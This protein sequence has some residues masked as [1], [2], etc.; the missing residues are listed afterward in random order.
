MTERSIKV[1]I[2]LRQAH[3]Y[4]LA[5]LDQHGGDPDWSEIAQSCLSLITH[6][7]CDLTAKFTDVSGYDRVVE[8]L[9][10]LG[11]DQDEA[12]RITRGLE[13]AVISYIVTHIPEFGSDHYYEQVSVR[14]VNDTTA[15]VEIKPQAL[16]EGV[17][18]DCLSARI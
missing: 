15:I 6:H 17:R 16:L 4:I 2:C 18:T 14:F 7:V 13:A 9:V 3:Q 10:N 8:L 1:L 12:C 5:Q 11:I